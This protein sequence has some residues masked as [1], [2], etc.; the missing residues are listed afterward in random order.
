[1]HR[2]RLVVPYVLRLIACRVNYLRVPVPLSRACTGN[3]EEKSR[4]ERAS[5]WISR[6]IS[7]YLYDGVIQTHGGYQA[8]KK[9]RMHDNRYK[10]VNTPLFLFIVFQPVLIKC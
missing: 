9:L 6:E 3:V 10:L 2:N 7:I 1:M 4:R 5:M 8:Y